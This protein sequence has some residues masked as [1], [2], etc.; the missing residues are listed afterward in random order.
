MLKNADLQAD[1]VVLPFTAVRASLAV[2]PAAWQCLTSLGPQVV[3][4]SCKSIEALV[5]MMFDYERYEAREG[6]A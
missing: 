4:K 3:V 1:P 6:D 5:Q 2:L